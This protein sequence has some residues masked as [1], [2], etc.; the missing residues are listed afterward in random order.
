MK[1]HEVPWYGLVQSNRIGIVDSVYSEPSSRSHSP[2]QTPTSYE[3]FAYPP[4]GPIT[5]VTEESSSAPPRLRPRQQ[6]KSTSSL[7]G[8]S[9]TDSCN[10]PSAG[11]Q[12][13]AGT[14]FHSGYSELNVTNTRRETI[15]NPVPNTRRVSCPVPFDRSAIDSIP[16][17]KM[18]IVPNNVREPHT[19][20]SPVI[21]R[22]S[23][24]PHL[25][26][27]SEDVPCVISSSPT[28][29]GPQ[30]AP[31]AP[32]D[33]QEE[34]VSGDA[35]LSPTTE[36]NALRSAPS[37]QSLEPIS[38]SVSK[39]QSL[40]TSPEQ[41]SE[42]PLSK[43]STSRQDPS[44]LLDSLPSE[45]SVPTSRPSTPPS[46]SPLQTISVSEQPTV[47]VPDASSSK[48]PELPAG[49]SKIPIAELEFSVDGNNRV[50]LGKHSTDDDIGPAKPKLKRLKLSFSSVSLD[51][52]PVDPISAST[53]GESAYDVAR[54]V[55][56]FSDESEQDAEAMLL[57]CKP[58]F[59]E[60]VGM[61]VWRCPQPWCT[62][63]YKQRNGLKYHIMKGYGR[64]FVSKS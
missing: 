64:I 55:I 34:V 28:P 8:Y 30:R 32:V 40:P 58:Q 42:A 44:S 13:D 12:G 53:S 59:S 5:P 1:H 48:L 56:S 24:R 45:N 54:S 10:R 9:D 7:Y 47:L 2:A 38:N 27:P 39:S 18:S 20:I 50:K 49:P 60:F 29:S 62:R 11:L 52:P 19:P 43:E 41:I 37:L 14:D 15:S 17:Q 16:R 3:S 35:G 61:S 22:P 57:H 6:M 23:P 33:S 4:T 31:N 25:H 63:V 46:R 26:D 51:Y 21:Q 36:G